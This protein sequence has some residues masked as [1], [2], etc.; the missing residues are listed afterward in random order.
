VFI[1]AS[2]ASS[3]RGKTIF[4]ASS[5]SCIKYKSI[6][7]LSF[8]IIHFSIKAS[9][10]L[11]IHIANQTAGISSKYPIFFDNISYLHHHQKVSWL[12]SVFQANSQ[13]V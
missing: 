3:E 13:T 12:F 2:L 7:S 6:L 5:Q 8:K 1:P 11:S 9:A 10:N 4:F